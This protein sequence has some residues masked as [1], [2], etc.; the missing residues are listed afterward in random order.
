MDRELLYL[1][2]PK[3]MEKNNNFNEI[4][5]LGERV[6]QK[7]EIKFKFSFA[8]YLSIMTGCTLLYGIITLEVYYACFRFNVF[9]FLDL[10][11]IAALI[12]ENLSAVILLIILSILYKDIALRVISNVIPQ[13]DY[14]KFMSELIQNRKRHVYKFFIFFAGIYAI[15]GVISYFTHLL[16]GTESL[17]VLIAVSIVPLLFYIEKELIEIKKEYTLKSTQAI[18]IYLIG[19]IFLIYL[20]ILQ[21]LLKASLKYEYYSRPIEIALKDKLKSDYF[22]LKTPDNK[23]DTITSNRNFFFIGKSSNY[24]F[25]YNRAHDNVEV[26]PNKDIIKYSF[27]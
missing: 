3:S 23:I 8:E 5:Y 21:G 6:I 17:T 22:L 2:K 10:K 13:N 27:R 18:G 14:N 19:I 24:V 7:K 4:I 20:P 1:V 12:V 11:E 25:F 15:V 26:Y 16:S 9:N